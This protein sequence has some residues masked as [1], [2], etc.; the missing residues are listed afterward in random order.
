M[1]NMKWNEKFKVFCV[2]KGLKYKEV[3]ELTG[4]AVGTVSNWWQG[5]MKPGK[6][7]Q[8]LL[9]EKL[10][11]SLD[12]FE[13]GEINVYSLF[14]TDMKWNNKFKAYCWAKRWSLE[15]VSKLTGFSTLTISSWFTGARRPSDK[16]KL[17][18]VEKLGIELSIFYEEYE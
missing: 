2:A 10:G 15:D 3:A 5:S 8:K 14:T 7:A 17:I 6:E 11:L 12:I 13:D 9:A 1:E 4:F 18:L 16:R